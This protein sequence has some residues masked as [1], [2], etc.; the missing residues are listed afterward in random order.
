MALNVDG[1]H[2]PAR[3]LHPDFENNGYIRSY[4]GLYTSTGKMHQ[5]EGNTISREDY[6]KGNTLFGFVFT[7]DMSEV[8]AFPAGKTRQ[9]ESEDLY[10]LSD[11]QMCRNIHGRCYENI[12]T[13]ERSHSHSQD[14]CASSNQ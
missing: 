3:P 6:A 9:L 12:E 2:I 11:T 7:P 5:D 1:R 14:F 13:P 4:M 10:I 8:G